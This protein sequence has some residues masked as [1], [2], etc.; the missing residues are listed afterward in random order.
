MINIVNRNN[1]NTNAT[2]ADFRGMRFWSPEFILDELGK[3]SEMG[4]KTIRIADEM[5]F[6]NKKYY[7]PILE[8]II[9]RG[10]DFNMW[11]YARVDTI[12]SDQLK[13]FKKAGIN[14]LCLGIEAGNQN[15]RLDIEKGKFKDVNIRDVVK[16][17]E[18]HKIE[19]L[20]NYMFGFPTDNLETMQETLDLAMELNTAHANFYATQALPGSPLY[21]QAKQN[22]WDLP[23]RYEEYAF[24]SY[25]CKPLPTNFLNAKEVL[26]FRDQAWHTYFSSEPFLKVVEDKFGSS[27]RNNVEKMSKIKS[28]EKEKIVAEKLNGRFAMI[29]FIA[30]VGAYLTTGQIIPGFI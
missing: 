7:V 12:R 18:D 16:Q 27:A 5:F 21:F 24:L 8:G 14:W 9:K 26:K 3:L 19:V 25:D 22:G 23:T 13:L 4:V 1:S 30:A 17:I 15:V 29:G 28:V 20:G 10:Y 11:A 6:L 2:A